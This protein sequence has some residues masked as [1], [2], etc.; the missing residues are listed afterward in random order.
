MSK[1]QKRTIRKLTLPLL[2][3]GLMT[4]MM[5]LG[6]GHASSSSAPGAAQSAQ[7]YRR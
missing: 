4:L 7:L 5:S 3:I 2:A 1:R 6:S